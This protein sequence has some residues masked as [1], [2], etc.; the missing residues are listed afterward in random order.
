MSLAGRLC[1][2]LPCSKPQDSD[3]NMGRTKG[4]FPNTSTRGFKG[5]LIFWKTFLRV[6]TVL[7]ALLYSFTDHAAMPCGSY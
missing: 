1:G 6:G 7:N 2:L 4:T 3:S 5:Q